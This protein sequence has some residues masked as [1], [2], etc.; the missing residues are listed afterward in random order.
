[1][2]PIYTAHTFVSISRHCLEHAKKAAI[3][4]QRGIRKR[5]P[6]ETAETLLEEL[7]SST[8][9]AADAGVDNKRLRF[10]QDSVA[11]KALG[12]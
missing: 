11:S 10:P 1:M 12:E 4:R 6:Q 9:I 3:M 8:S 2:L 5:R 7:A